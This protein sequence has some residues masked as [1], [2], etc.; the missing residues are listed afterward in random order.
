MIEPR[1]QTAKDI[2]DELTRD[3]SDRLRA[4]RKAAGLSQQQLATELDTSYSAVQS[5]ESSREPQLPSGRNVLRIQ[6]RLAVPLLP[7]S[8][9][10]VGDSAKG[11]YRKA[12]DSHPVIVPRGARAA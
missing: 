5:W 6:L 9:G 4:A 11:R 3:Y 12:M 7:E 8:P 10:T 2:I 1:V